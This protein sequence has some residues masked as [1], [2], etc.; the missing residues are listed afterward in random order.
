MSDPLPSIQRQL[1]RLQ[2]QKQNLFG[3]LNAL[4]V[5]DFFRQPDAN[6]WSIGQIAN[7]LYLSERNSMA[8]LK[9][10][11]SYPD[12]VPRFHFK[13]WGGIILI[14]LVFGLHIRIKAPDSINVWKMDNLLSRDELEQKWN[15][16]R[17]DMKDYLELQVPVFKNKL[18]YRHPF[19]GRMSMH[20]M[21][22]F[23]NDHFRHH[24]RQ[25][26][27]VLSHHR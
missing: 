26:N 23:L 25:I 15:E 20:Q 5:E 12:T 17:Q 16:L 13:S 6:R 18:A 11:L 10:K 7:H 8:Y 1:H 9:K 21:V 19:A 2:L 14:R 22:M 3:I 24:Q 4:P 27:R